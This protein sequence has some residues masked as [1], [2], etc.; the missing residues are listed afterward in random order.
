MRIL[1]IGSGGREH[2]LCWKLRQSKTVDALYAAPGNAGTASLARNIAIPSDDVSGLHSFARGEEIDLTVVGPEKP[3]VAGLVDI[4]EKEGMPIVGPTA[5]AAQLEGSKAYSKAFMSEFGIPTARYRVFQAH[6]F[7]EATAYVDDHDEPLVIK[8]SGLAAGKGAFVCQTRAEA[9][10][11]LESVMREHLLGEAGDEV[12]VEEFMEGEEASV[13]ALSDGE[14][15]VLLPTAQ[16]H[17]RL[18]DGDGGP[19]TGGMGAYSPAPVV[20]QSILRQVCNG[21]I[22]PTLAGMH[23][24]GAPYRGFLY[25]GL[26]LTS[27]GPKV[28]EYNCRLGDPEAQVVLPLIESDFAEVLHKLAGG[29]LSDVRIRVREGSAACVV[30]ASGGYPGSY[31]KGFVVEGLDDVEDALVFHAGTR[32]N[33]G[34]EVVTDGGRVLGVTG[35]GDDLEAALAGIYAAASRITFNGAFYRRDIGRKGIAFV[36]ACVLCLSF[37]LPAAAQA[38]AD[39]VVSLGGPIAAF[40]EAQALAVAPQGIV[41][42]V[43]AGIDALVRLHPETNKREELGG[44]GFEAGAFLS[45]ADVDATNGLVLVVADAGNHRIQRF[46]NEFRLLE[47]LSVLAGRDNLSGIETGV[48]TIPASAPRG[49][50]VSVASASDGALYAVDAATDRVIKWNANRSVAWTL[51]GSGAP[52]GRLRTP[53]DL[54]LSDEW[55]FVAD[56][57]RGAVLVYDHFGNYARQIRYPGPAPIQSVFLA[58][59]RL[60]LVFPGAVLVYEVEGR[61]LRA[62]N[63]GNGV[64]LVDA[65]RRGDN[66]LL[67]TQDALHVARVTDETPLLL[68]R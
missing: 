8:A 14:R 4:F 22:E 65:A 33:E 41:Y 27:D 38:P 28:V 44:P 26:M 29:R 63:I 32:H 9:L 15:Y 58:A 48:R 49:S 30:M 37:A 24:R 13:F 40:E 21:I 34:G 55:L 35:V 68:Q 51:G 60:H 16:D 20:T 62:F 47:E 42:V 61:L 7:D 52:L 45:P 43:D 1:V 6:Q 19:N 39:T 50:P 56:R 64:A 3:L 23:A 59:E 66:L 11:V 18:E 54:A 53:V 25:C 67:L 57:G 12:V 2:A 10:E 5:E 36:L 46:T 31:E 17:K